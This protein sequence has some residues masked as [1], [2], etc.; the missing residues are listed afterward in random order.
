M[1]STLTCGNPFSRATRGFLNKDGTCGT[2][3]SIAMRG[4]LI[5]I[6]PDGDGRFDI[7]I[8]ERP[9][10]KGGGP[11]PGSFAEEE[12]ILLVIR[13]FLEYDSRGLL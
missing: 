2:P 4:Y 5:E 3:L 7:K 10:L 12:E 11:I 1:A 9:T 13:L 8:R 6:I